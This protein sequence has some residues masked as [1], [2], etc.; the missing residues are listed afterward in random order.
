MILK[1]S[2]GHLHVLCVAAGILHCY[3]FLVITASNHVLIREVY[4]S[5]FHTL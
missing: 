1:A 2:S 4:Y 3:R 5:L